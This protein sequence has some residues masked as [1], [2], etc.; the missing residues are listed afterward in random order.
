MFLNA[1]WFMWVFIPL[2]LHSRIINFYMITH[3]DVPLGAIWRSY[4]I[5]GWHGD[6]K[7]IF[8]NP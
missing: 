3:S 2:L 8:D 4:W 5:F 6:L 1:M 7:V